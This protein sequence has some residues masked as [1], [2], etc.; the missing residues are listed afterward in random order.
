MR[1]TYD[2]NRQPRFEMPCRTPEAAAMLRRVAVLKQSLLNIDSH[3]GAIRWFAQSQAA[4]CRA[5]LEDLNERLYSN[6]GRH[7]E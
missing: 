4:A 1:V 6:G 7:G 3:D 5:E 2:T